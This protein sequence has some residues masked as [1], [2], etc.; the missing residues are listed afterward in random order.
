MRFKEFIFTAFY[1]GYSPVAPGTA[2]T[3]VAMALYMLENII[4]A[5]VN[6]VKIYIINLLLL[7]LAIYPSIK[8]GDDAEKFFKSKD[9]QQVVIDEVIGYWVG[10]LFIPFTFTNAVF[11][12]ILFRVFDIIKPFPAG[13]LEELSGGLGIVIDDVIAGIYTLLSMHILV[14]VLYHFN[15]VLP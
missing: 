11:A 3:L 9:P 5:D 12:F 6:P 1:S 8:L 7:L 14:N 4:F 2:G 10:I 15:I 13:S